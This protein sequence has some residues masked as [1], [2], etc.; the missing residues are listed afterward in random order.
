MCLSLQSLYIKLRRVLA[1]SSFISL[2][3]I[4]SV[5][6]EYGEHEYYTGNAGTQETHC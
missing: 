6:A 2:D 4:V 3:I 1:T 5:V